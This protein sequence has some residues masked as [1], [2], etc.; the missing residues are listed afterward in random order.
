MKTGTALMVLGAGAIALFT[1]SKSAQGGGSSSFF[2]PNK[3]QMFDIESELRKTRA[4]ASYPIAVVKEKSLKGDTGY[5]EI[6]E[7]GD[8]FVTPYRVVNVGDGGKALKTSS[9]GQ[10]GSAISSGGAIQFKGSQRTM[11][12]STG[13]AKKMSSF[14]LL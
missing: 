11:G 14:G 7:G 6:R 3:T 9:S 2:D 1:L 13:F 4:S 10:T 12:M 8:N 5:T